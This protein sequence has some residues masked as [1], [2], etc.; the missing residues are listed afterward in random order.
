VIETDPTTWIL[1]ATGRL[2]WATAV[3]EGRLRTSGIRAD[4]SAY[5][6]I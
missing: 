6:P 4:I 3:A 2:D 5:I 1:V